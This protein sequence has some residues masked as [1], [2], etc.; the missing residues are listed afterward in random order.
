M[1]L[2]AADRL[3]ILDLYARYGFAFDAA[4]AEEWASLFAADGRFIRPGQPDLQGPEDL[5]ALCRGRATST[6]GIRH[7]TANVTIAPSAGGARGRAYV[8]V[9]RMDDDGSVRLYTLGCY[10]D[11]LV[12]LAQGWRFQSRTFLPWL[13]PE[14]WDTPLVEGSDAEVG[15]IA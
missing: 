10:E 13:A 11:E 6:P 4:E 14:L 12:K 7:F 8:I 1:A 2:D 5:A 3:E 15:S 9:L